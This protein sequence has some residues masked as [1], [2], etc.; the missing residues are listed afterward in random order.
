MKTR[1]PQKKAKKPMPSNKSRTSGATIARKGKSL[2][3]LETISAPSNETAFR[4]VLALIEGARAR[5]LQAVNTELIDLYWRVR[6]EINRRIAADGW[7]KSTISSLAS[8]VRQEQP[9]LRGFSS[10]NL[11]RMRQLFDAYARQTKLSALLRELS[12]TCNLL[13]LG[14]CRGVIN[15]GMS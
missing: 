14:R 10:Q 9:N 12:W 8:Y 11:W 1:K 4:E 6:E 15:E 2:A 13:I 7:G 5:A 3:N